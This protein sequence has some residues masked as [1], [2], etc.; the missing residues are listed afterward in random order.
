MAYIT[1]HNQAPRGAFANTV[2]M[3]GDPLRSKYIAE[4]FL[5]AAELVNNVRGVQGYTGYYK[6]KRVS[7]MAS[8]MGMPAIG[9]YSQELFQFYDVTSVIRIGSCGSLDRDLHI[10]D[11]IIAQGAC[12]DSNYADQYR[13]P[14]TFCPI[15]SWRLLRAAADEAAA[16]GLN[17]KVGNVLSSDHFYNDS[18]STLD[19]TRMG[20]LG[21][22][23]EAAALYCNAARL[24]KDALCILTVSDSLVGGEPETS[25][26]ERERTFTDMVEVAL[27]I[28]D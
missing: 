25:P 20:V 24:K 5:D 1:P 11:L 6:G 9:I 2:L 8:G 4:N 7:V 21:V 3:P 28:A 15:G 26:E 17:F 23:M 27:T 22:E 16:R 18:R 10:R 12:T 14:G 19:W 13:L